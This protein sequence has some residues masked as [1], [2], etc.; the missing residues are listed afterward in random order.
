MQF[1]KDWEGFIYLFRNK[2]IHIH[3]KIQDIEEMNLREG[4]SVTWKGWKGKGKV[5]NVIIF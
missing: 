2:H 4:K 3:Y 1:Y 5:E